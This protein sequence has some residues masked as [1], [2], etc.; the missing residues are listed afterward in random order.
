MALWN[1][2][3]WEV[4]AEAGIGH[5]RCRRLTV[6]AM[7]QVSLTASQSGRAPPPVSVSLPHEESGVRPHFLE[8]WYA[9]VYSWVWEFE[10][11]PWQCEKPV[12]QV[13]PSPLLTYMPPAGFTSRASHQLWKHENMWLL[14]ACWL[15][16]MGLLWVCT[17]ILS[18][19]ILPAWHRREEA[20]CR[21]WSVMRVEHFQM[22]VYNP[23]GSAVPAKWERNNC[24]LQN[25]EQ[26]RTKV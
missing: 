15:P 10:C 20:G 8:K 2:S 1:L 6:G 24:V 22:L 21:S 18:V 12:T 16:L 11:F 13:F 26:K 19:L 4:C 23:F 25:R 5:L 9:S 7:T 17:H 3:L 14:L